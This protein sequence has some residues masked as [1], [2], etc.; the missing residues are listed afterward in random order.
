MQETRVRSLGWE[1]PL[2]KEVA[3]HSS[4]LDWRIPWT[5]K[6]RRL[7]STGSQRVG[8]HWATSLSL[9]RNIVNTI[10]LSFVYVVVQLPS[11]VR[12]FATPW[13]AA[14]QAPLSS[15]TSWSLFSFM[16]IG[17]VMLSNHSIL[18]HPLLLLPSIFPNVRVFS[19]ELTFCIKWP[20]NWSFNFSMSPSKWI[21][22]VDF[23]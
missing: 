8:H 19:R 1:A 5:E 2:E 4:I 7:Q 16:W 18:C 15:T 10:K 12:L 22:R 6:P 13:T 21:F 11:Y 3:I 17:L 20:N 23:L 9:F 14:H